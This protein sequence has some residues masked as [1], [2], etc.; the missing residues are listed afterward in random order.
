MKKI[1]KA[2]FLKNSAQT[3]GEIVDSLE[4]LPAIQLKDLPREQTALV[5]IDMINGFTREGTLK[6]PRIEEII[7]EVAELSKKC[8]KYGIPE[9]VFK[10]PGLTRC[11]Y[12]DRD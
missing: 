1:N 12:R 8:S 9:V 5:I 10:F 4:K 3:L 2:G 6:S 11:I 7:P